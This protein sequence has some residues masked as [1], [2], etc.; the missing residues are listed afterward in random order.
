MSELVERVARAIEIPMVDMSVGMT[1][2]GRLELIARAAI[3]EMP[4]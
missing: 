1:P 2:Q 3:E 4:E